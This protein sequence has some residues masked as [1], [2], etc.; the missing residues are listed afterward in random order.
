MDAT[1]LPANFGA[2]AA[3]SNGVLVQAV[4]TDGTSVLEDFGTSDVP[5]TN[6]AEW[7]RIA[8][9]GEVKGGGTGVDASGPVSLNL[10]ATGRGLRLTA[11]QIFQVV[12]QDD[13]T[14]LTAMKALIQGVTKAV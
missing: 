4:D 13:L 2:I 7:D 1:M 3:L 14:G 5:I 8:S 10:G 6:N 12:I 11:G 9:P